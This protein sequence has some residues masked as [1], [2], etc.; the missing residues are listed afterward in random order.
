ME[1]LSDG[2]RRII[3]PARLTVARI[4]VLRGWGPRE[5][6]PFIDDYIQA[7]EPIIDYHTKYSGIKPGDLDP[8]VSPHPLTTLKAAYMKLRLLCDLGCVFVGHGLKQD[9]RTISLFFL[10]PRFPRPCSYLFLL[11]ILVP[12]DQVID[13]VEIFRIKGQRKISLKFL[14]WFLLRKDIQ[15]ETH[16]SVED[17]RTVK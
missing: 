9:F 10:L 2:T 16:C 12:S 15:R 17:A 1:V 6:T 5:G 4:S 11:D 3:K 13:T 7:T 14:A 8:A